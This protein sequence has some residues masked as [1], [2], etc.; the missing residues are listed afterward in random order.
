MHMRLK[1]SSWSYLRQKDVLADSMRRLR[2]ILRYPLFNHPQ[3]EASTQ[4]IVAHSASEIIR[5]YGHMRGT[6]KFHSTW[7][8]TRRIFTAGQIVLLC[9]DIGEIP[10]LDFI[11]LAELVLELLHYQTKGCLAAQHAE[12]NWVKL[13]EISGE[14]R[15]LISH[16]P[17]L[18]FGAYPRRH[19]RK[20]YSP[21]NS[22]R[23]G[24]RS[25]F[26]I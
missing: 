16:G 20:R 25:C 4:T 23:P 21:W 1:R 3:Y 13:M 6:P 8:E 22:R 15:S 12:D 9:W 19:L 18:V 5:V 26:A 7:S 11:G 2:L 17:V 10:T 24:N 14:L